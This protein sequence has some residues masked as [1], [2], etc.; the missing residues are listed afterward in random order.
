MTVSE[1]VKELRKSMNLT[2]EKF[3]NKLGVGKSAL[4]KIENGE[5]GLTDQMIKLM[6]KE[7]GVSENWLRT[8]EGEMLPHFSRADAIAKLADD[9]MTEVPDSFKSRLVT[10]L[11][12]MSDEQ[13]KLLEDFTYKVVGNEYPFSAQKD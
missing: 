6:V 5:N 7:F 9:I 1:R 11:A 8:G 2:L 12:Q 10:A 13:W 3:G 4:S